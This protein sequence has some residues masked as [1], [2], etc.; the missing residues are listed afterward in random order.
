MKTMLAFAFFEFRYIVDR[1]T[2]WKN[3][4]TRTC[5]QN[6]YFNPY[7]RQQI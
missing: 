5:T 6:Y 3:F 7:K 1:R 2:K 4:K